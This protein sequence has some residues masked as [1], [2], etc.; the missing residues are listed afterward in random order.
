MDNFKENGRFFDKN[1]KFRETSELSH[2]EKNA[3][4]LWDLIE[5]YVKKYY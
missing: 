2:N 4:E 5:S 1:T 3:K